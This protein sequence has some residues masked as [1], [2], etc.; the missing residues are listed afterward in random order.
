MAE[1]VGTLPNA[2]TVEIAIPVKETAEKKV[3]WYIATPNPQMARS[4]RG[5]RKEPR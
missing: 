1:N 2:V 3:S 5:A 4:R